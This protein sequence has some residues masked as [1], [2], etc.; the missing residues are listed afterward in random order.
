M[1]DLKLLEV[2]LNTVPNLLVAVDTARSLFKRKKKLKVN[3]LVLD[4]RSRINWAEYND[5]VEKRY[6]VCGNTLMTVPEQ[7]VD[8]I[9]T[10]KRIHECRIILSDYRDN[11]TS[12]QQLMDYTGAVPKNQAAVASDVYTI[13]TT[14]FKNRDANPWDHVRLY[15][16][17][18][19]QNITIYDDV[20]FFSPYDQTGIGNNTLTVF[21]SM[22]DNKELFTHIEKLFLD[23]WELCPCPP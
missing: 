3:A 11:T 5:T 13:L 1:L 8:H 14:Y 10:E 7:I 23:M 6:W 15:D 9:Y 17:I 21:C 2:N 22:K 16:K 12:K 20:A 19:F 18:M 4:S